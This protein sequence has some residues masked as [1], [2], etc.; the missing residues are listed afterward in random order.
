MIPDKLALLFRRILTPVVKTMT[1]LGITPLGLTLTGLVI[2]LLSAV[3]LCLG[4]LRLGA[5]VLILASIFDTLDGS[6]ARYSNKQS[7]FG[8]FL[9]SSLDRI[10]EFMIL[11]S[12]VYWAIFLSSWTPFKKNTFILVSFGVL[13]CSLFT[14]Y[15]KARAEGLKYKFKGGFFSR[16]ERVIWLTVILLLGKYFLYWGMLL[17]LLFTLITSLERFFKIKGIISS[18]G[19]N[20]QQES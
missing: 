20:G 10:S 2:T 4:Y 12:L 18:G 8:A 3:L 19:K 5:V 13:F 11:A 15:V 17:L 14:S 1:K 16:P 7:D 6:L 9:D